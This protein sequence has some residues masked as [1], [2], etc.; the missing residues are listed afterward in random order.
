MVILFYDELGYLWLGC[1]RMTE[2]YYSLWSSSRKEILKYGTKHNF[3]LSQDTKIE[4]KYRTVPGKWDVWSP[5]WEWVIRPSETEDQLNLPR[6]RCSLFHWEDSWIEE[7]SCRSVWSW[8]PGGPVISDT[9]SH[10]ALSRFCW[11][12]AGLPPLLL[13]SFQS[14]ARKSSIY[15]QSKCHF[16]SIEEL[17][18]L[19]KHKWL[20]N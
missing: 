19:Y 12:P 2:H 4:P 7:P 13:F 11:S 3:F 10:I 14:M 5:Y 9:P 16:C 17:L 20:Q 6:H 15:F 1:N 8:H 18:K